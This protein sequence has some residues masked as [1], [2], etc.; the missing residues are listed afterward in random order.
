MLQLL[1]GF[2]LLAVIVADPVPEPKSGT[3]K[4]SISK[5]GK[6]GEEPPSPTSRRSL[7]SWLD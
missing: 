5:A 7:T 4:S 2:C 3:S 6:K 1:L